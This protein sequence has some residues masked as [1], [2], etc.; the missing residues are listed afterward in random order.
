MEYRPLGR[1]GVKVSPLCL[2][3]WMF[4]D[5]AT[6]EESRAIINEALDA[7]I[8]FLDTS[9]IYGGAPGRSETIVGEA[10]RESGR[11]DRL[12]LATKVFFPTDPDDPN[13]R[14]VSRR[15]IIASC[16]QSLRRLQTDCIDLVQMH[17]V[18]RPDDPEV[19]H[20]PGGAL[21]ALVAAR[22]AGKL[23]YIGFTGHKEPEIHLKMIDTNRSFPWDAVQM[24]LN[25][26][27]RHFNSFEAKVLPVLVERGIGVLGMKP[28]AGGRILETGAVSAPECLR[29]A[30][31]LPTSVVITGC[32]N[33]EQVQQALKAGDEFTPLSD[34]ELRDLLTRSAAPAADGRHERYKTSDLHDG[35]KHNP[36]WLTT[37][38]A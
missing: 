16:E 19:I 26:F 5:R 6:P 13:A 36:H 25:C 1:T 24:P 31:S 7:G 38:A 34:E 2:G 10:V 3:C 29:Y 11:R 28:L 20:A 9:N 35:T 21:E 17:E 23:R 8:N 14:G 27:D 22:Q 18:I 37:A 15:H 33:V 12:V 30:L 32:E 4:G